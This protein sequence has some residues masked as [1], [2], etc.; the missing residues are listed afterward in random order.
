MVP[1][2]ILPFGTYYKQ[3]IRRVMKNIFKF[4]MLLFCSQVYAAK[5]QEVYL[6]GYLSNAAKAWAG[7]LTK[8]GPS[9]EIASYVQEA[10]D[11]NASAF[12]DA[13]SVLAFNSTAISLFEITHHISQ[14]FDVIS[15]PIIARKNQCTKN[16]MNC[17]IASQTIVIDGEVF[18]AFADYDSDNNGSF[19][20]RNTGF[21]INAKSFVSDGWQ[22]GVSYTRSMTDTQDSK[23]YA[24]AVSNSITIFSEYLA[25]SGFFINMGIN[26]GNTSWATDKNIAGIIDNSAYDTEF[27]AGQVN[28]GFRMH[29]GRITMT[30]QVGVK[31]AIINADKYIDSVAQE[32]K[33]WWYNALTGFIG[34][35]LGFDFIGSDFIVR[36]NLN[37]G[38]SYDAISRGTESLEVQ[39][40]DGSY[41]AIPIEKPNRMAL[42]AGIGVNVYGASYST[43]LNY[44]FD[45]RSNY[46]SN[47]VMMN[48]KIA[49]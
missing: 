38:G 43:G 12:F 46:V 48:L 45:M 23:V 7:L 42:N 37:I 28:T 19:K 1:V 24:D 49:F 6:Y 18:G 22:I 31:Y 34:L 27:M 44:K 2:K 17:D 16:L 21:H 20:T 11:N 40:I 25:N 14:A 5:A 30:P 10:Q 33:S 32:F 9:G 3:K 26:G 39:L 29:R 47:T 13:I 4:I 35:K 8:L 41:Y 36:P 15:E